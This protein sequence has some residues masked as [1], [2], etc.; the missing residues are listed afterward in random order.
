MRTVRVLLA[1]DQPTL[2]E[3]LA[4]LIRDEP[5]LELVG[6]AGDALQTIALA[7]QTRPDVAVVDVRMPGGGGPKA[8]RG[9]RR[10]SPRSRV[11]ALSAHD[12]RATVLEMLRSGASGYLVK[13]TDP[14]RILTAIRD[15]ADGR[16]ALSTQV[17][18]AVI[19]ELAAKLRRDSSAA[20]LRTRQAR[21]VR[22]ALGKG[23]LTMHFQ[24]ILT[25]E[26]QEL[27]GVEA[28]AR[29]AAPPIRGPLE[30]FEEAEAVGL[31]VELE[32]SAAQ[33]AIDQ[34]E[35]IPRQAYLSVNL[36][37]STAL[38]SRFVAMLD[39]V[40]AE[41]VVVEVTEHAPVEDYDTLNA[42]MG[43]LRE[44]GV[45][46]AIDDAGAG[47]ASLRHIVRLDPDII[48]LDISLTRGIDRDPKRRALASALIA[49][50]AEIGAGIVAEGIEYP[51][52][53]EQLRALGV[54]CGQGY[55]LARPGPLP[56]GTPAGVR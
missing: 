43:P 17:T 27:V 5:G 51:E 2:R 23:R 34:L 44:R 54:A 46:L 26:D 20:E 14:E 7:R 32:L 49:F 41:R 8:A 1:E 3:A 13:G 11:V 24:P 53:R 6:M 55:F 37:A 50:A 25:L 18:A 36:S 9:I 39:G 33:C 35:S 52:E 29:F 10:T 4:D 30:W 42:A 47:F 22:R 16:G 12:D 31:R 28:L 56:L 45:K 40:P 15:A 48:K 19:E 38:S 21:R